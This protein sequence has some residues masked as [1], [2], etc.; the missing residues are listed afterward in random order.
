[1]TFEKFATNE[2]VRRVFRK[3]NKPPEKSFYDFR[4][5][6]FRIFY[7]TKLPFESQ[8]G[9]GSQVCE[10]VLLCHFL[11]LY[12]IFYEFFSKC[13][14][15]CKILFDILDFYKKILFSQI[16]LNYPTPHHQITIINHTNLPTR[17]R[18]L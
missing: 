10:A 3:N 1:M 16:L 8:K 14:K 12:T 9:Y 15:N 18:A 7:T 13:Q 11:K 5:G 6:N 4:W 17:N 2:E